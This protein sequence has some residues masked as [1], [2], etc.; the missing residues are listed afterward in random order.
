[1]RY[2]SNIYT[3]NADRIKTTVGQNLIGASAETRRQSKFSCQ[4]TVA[5]V[6]LLNTK[7]EFL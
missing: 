5:A 2:A 3:A 1:M 4:E 6:S 7:G